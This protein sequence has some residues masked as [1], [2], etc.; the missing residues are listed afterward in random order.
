MTHSRTRWVTISGRRL[1][2]ICDNSGS[3]RRGG[4]LRRFG[5]REV[6]AFALVVSMVTACEDQASEGGASRGAA[7]QSGSPQS[8]SPQSGTPSATPAPGRQATPSKSVAPPDLRP[9]NSAGTSG[10]EEAGS[11]WPT[12]A[13]TGVPHGARL[14]KSG[15]LRVRR[16]GAVIDGKEIRQEISI[17]ADNVTIRNTHLIGSGEWG[18]IQRRGFSGLRVERSEINGDGRTKTQVGILNHGGALTVRNTYIHTVSDGINTDQGLI[19]DCVITKLKEFPGDHNDGIASGSGPPSGQS[20]V[21]RHNVIL[22]PL[23]QTSAVALFQDFGRAHDV[24]V[25]RNYLAGGGYAL[26][27]GQGRFGKVSNIKITGNVFSRRFY[28][29]GGYHGPVTAFDP[30]GSGNV[31]SD[32]VWEETG[33]PVRP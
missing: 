25:D 21:I 27:G 4:S 29:K 5:A 24:T 3:S 16:N 10:G 18:I 28:Q 12:L 7:S 20:L 15:P 23:G 26:Y 17:E 30:S 6:L 8:G 14:T 22:N 13:T 2:A 19:E 9:G 33:K 1:M 31:W 11:G 32:N